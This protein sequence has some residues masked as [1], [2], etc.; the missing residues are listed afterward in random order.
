MYFPGKKDYFAY[1]VLF[2]VLSE[3][4]SELDFDARYG[5]FSDEIGAGPEYEY[6]FSK[7]LA[8][9]IAFKTANNELQQD[10]EERYGL[11]RHVGILLPSYP[12]SLRR[13]LH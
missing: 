5:G 6:P 3:R 9:T 7:K 8:E 11:T 13:L 12:M 1:F 10:I 4:M 2:C